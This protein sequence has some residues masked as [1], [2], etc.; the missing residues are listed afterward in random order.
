M[1]SL[2]LADFN[3][4]LPEDLVAHEPLSDRSAS[5]LLVRSPEG[6]LTD[7]MFKDL[8][9]ILPKGTRL[10]VNDTR[11][12][13]GRL[14]ARTS[15]GGKIELML[16]KVV[17]IKKNVWQALGKPFRKL[18]I[19]T[20]LELDSRCSA[21]IETQQGDEV[22]PWVEVSFSLSYE[23]FLEW[24]EKSGYIPLPPYIERTQAEP[25]PQSRDRERYQTIYAREKGSVAAPTAGLHFSTELWSAL[26]AAGIEI[27]P[28]TLHVGAGTFLPVK[29]NHLDQHQMHS[30]RYSISRESWGRL[31]E[32][33][34]E[35]LPL[36][37]VGT[38]SLRCL[39]SF[40]RQSLGKSPEA[41]CD[42]WHETDLFI[43][44]QNR[45]DRVKP[46]GLTGIIT[47]FHQP[48]SSLL[49]LVAAL[50]GYEGMRALYAEAI[51]RR[52]RFF[53]YGDACYLHLA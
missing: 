36:V 21:R 9:Q 52:Y 4:I 17:D 20:T 19:G 1:Q 44:P 16:L 43:Y 40:V 2:S 53:S 28:L 23:E 12:L 7:A 45:E 37:A 38:T 31:Q 32:A 35:G 48:E 22:Q 13:P 24:M 26:K 14:L 8:P 33:Q 10:I 5:R 29:T 27:I 42:E 18:K 41:F 49:M 46:W 6:Q 30:E 3:Y 51:L 50:I 34:A 39:E 25:A 47:N 11:V 15:H